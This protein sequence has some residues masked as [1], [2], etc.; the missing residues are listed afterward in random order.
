MCP[1]GCYNI[2]LNQNFDENQDST[3]TARKDIV[4]PRKCEIVPFGAYSPE[5]NDFMYICPPGT[6]SKPGSIECTL[7]PPG[8]YS[9]RN[10]SGACFECSS[11]LVALYAGSTSCYDCNDNDNQIKQCTNYTTDV[12]V[13]IYPT[14]YDISMSPSEQPSNLESQLIVDSTPSFTSIMS[15]QPT[16][17]MTT[18]KSLC[19]TF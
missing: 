15:V 11:G 1:A 6:F 12:N 5:N 8:S 4:L 16:L 13:S 9:F 7:C 10:G 18:G 14:K 17:T 3:P 19:I 2:A